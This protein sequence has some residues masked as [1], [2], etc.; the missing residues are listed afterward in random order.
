MGS[1]M[2]HTRALFPLRLGQ[3]EH[4]EG[5]AFSPDGAWFG[6]LGTVEGELFLGADGGRRRMQLTAGWGMYGRF[7]VWAPTSDGVVLISGKSLGVLD[8][9]DASVRPM[10]DIDPPPS[11]YWGGGPTWRPWDREGRRLAFVRG[12]Q[13]WISD[14]TGANARP[15]TYE[16]AAKQR[17]VFSPDGSRIAYIAWQPN[18]RRGWQAL[19]DVWVVDIRTTLTV[20]ITR[21]DAGSTSGLDWLDRDRLIFDRIARPAGPT[22]R[23][24]LHVAELGHSADGAR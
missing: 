23:S 3:D 15:L 11:S 2:P 22:Y 6:P 12:G 4:G 13:V 20:R 21:S 14:L 16:S 7:A 8:F 9:G 17:P 18:H 10:G 1:H 24:T 19:T 5:A